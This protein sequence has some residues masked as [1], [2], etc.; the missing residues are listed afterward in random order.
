MTPANAADHTTAEKLTFPVLTDEGL[1]VA[2]TYGLVFVLDETVRPIYEQFGIDLP[3]ANG[4][5]SFELPIPATYVIDRSGKIT[6]AY[7]DLDYRA[8][9][10]PA[11]ILEA[12]KKL[13]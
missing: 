4:N 9:A 1:K 8:R 10:E 2:K 3:A 5:T 13:D 6:W 12:L 11:D 7:R